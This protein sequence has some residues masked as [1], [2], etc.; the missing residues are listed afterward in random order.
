MPTASGL[1]R[2]HCEKIPAGGISAPCR[3]RGRNPGLPPRLP[4]RSALPAQERA[5]VHGQR[6][7]LPTIVVT[8][9]SQGTGALF[10]YQHAGWRLPGFAAKPCN[11]PRWPSAPA[12][13]PGRRCCFLPARVASAAWA[14]LAL[15]CVPHLLQQAQ[16]SA[17]VAMRYHNRN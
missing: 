5:G 12:L 11:G 2:K 6:T 16:A 4:P 8:K 15:P 9:S 10:P 13:Q 17:V 7:H 14:G 1:Q 3:Q